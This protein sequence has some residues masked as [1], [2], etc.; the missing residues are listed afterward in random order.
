MMNL[1]FVYDLPFG[2]GKMLASSG[3]LAKVMGGWSV[4]GRARYSSGTPL[5]ISDSNGRPI[6]LRN[7]AKSGAIRERIGDRVDPVTKEVLN[8]Y[9]DTTAFASLPTQYTISP[10]VPFFGEL[11]NPPSK[12]LDAS[13]VRRIAIRERLKFDIRADASSLTNTPQWGS[14]GT[15]MS[16]KATF[17]V[18]QSAGGNR[19]V[20]LSF[21]AVF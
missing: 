10:E 11:R 20:Q 8:P 13:I 9:F 14:P 21:R 6:R 19:R 2:N 17:G 12:T 3:M 1:A 18:I 16:N 5:S 7:A 4:S 15:S